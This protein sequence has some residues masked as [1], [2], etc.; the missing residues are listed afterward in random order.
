MHSELNLFKNPYIKIPSIFYERILTLYPAPLKT[1]KGTKWGYVDH[2]GNY[3]IKPKHDY[4]MNSQ[5]NDLAVVSMNN[6]FGIINISWNYI[7]MPQYGGINDFFEERAIVMDDKGFKTI[8]ESGK[9]LTSKAY[10]YIGSLH[11]REQC[12]AMQIRIIIIYMVI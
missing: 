1:A 7:V 2:N 3:N 5:S 9:V 6:L 4:A 10:S 11:E 12:L 8:A